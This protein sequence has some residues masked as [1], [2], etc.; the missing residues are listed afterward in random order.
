VDLIHVLDY[1]WQASR[2]FHAE[3]ATEGED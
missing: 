2:P 3:A 1:L